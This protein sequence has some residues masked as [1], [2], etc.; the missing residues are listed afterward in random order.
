MFQFFASSCRDAPST[1]TEVRDEKR[2]VAAS[3]LTSKW[4]QS[5]HLTLSLRNNYHLGTQKFG[6]A[7]KPAI[8]LLPYIDPSQRKTRDVFWAFID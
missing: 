8:H 7:D 1:S 4:A 2:T 5:S 3:Q 6:G